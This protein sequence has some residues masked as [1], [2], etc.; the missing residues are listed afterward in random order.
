[1][2]TRHFEDGIASSTEVPTLALRQ[3]CTIASLSIAGVAAL[4]NVARVSVLAVCM[5]MVA[6]HETCGDQMV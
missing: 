2:S 5:M 4:T 3:A 6:Y 1:M